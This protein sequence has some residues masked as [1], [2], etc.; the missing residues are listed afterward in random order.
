VPPILNLNRSEFSLVRWLARSWQGLD[1][2]RMNAIVR[3]SV[4][5]NVAHTPTLVVT[6]R[7]SRLLELRQSDD[8]A[9]RLLPRYY[10]DLLWNPQEGLPYLRGVSAEDTQALQAEIPKM[11]QFV[12]LLHEAGVRIHVGSDTF[13][14]FVVPG[15]SVH[16]ELRLLVDAGLTP[17]EAW[18]AATRAAGESLREPGLGTVQEGAPADFLIFRQDPSKDLAALATLEAVVAQGRLY[19]KGALDQA[20]SRWRAHFEAPLYDAVTM[21]IARAVVKRLF[22]GGH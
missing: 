6:E 9:A 21:T 7:L 3:A 15:V 4:E 1:V 18:S 8:E 17:E 20:L 10:R 11:K 19:P 2:A 12:R 14:P 22:T 16:E 5:H 13:N